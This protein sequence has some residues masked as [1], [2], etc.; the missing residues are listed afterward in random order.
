GEEWNPEYKE[1]YSRKMARTGLER[2]LRVLPET[3]IEVLP[4][5][6]LSLEEIEQN[7]KDGAY[8]VKAP[9][10]SSGKGL[11]GVSGQLGRKEKEW[12][13]GML[14]RQG[15]L[16]LEKRLDKVKDFAAEF[17]LGEKGVQF[18]GW[19]VFITGK[20]GEYRGNYIGASGNLE[21]EWNDYFS[22]HYSAL[23]IR[24]LSGMLNEL[25][26]CY[27]GYLGVDMMV[28][29]NCLGKYVVQPCVEINLRYNM[30][31]VA[32]HLYNRYIED[33]SR[34]MFEIRYF[35]KPGQALDEHLRLQQ[36]C[37]VVYKN[38]RIKSGYLN[39]TPVNES[40]RFVACVRCY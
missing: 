29:R 39:L 13:A 3:E 6:C 5:I 38:N 20:H 24:E 14:H 12:L 31:I 18:I 9:W 11:L 25:F 34:G 7:I 4:R 35:S 1:W 28:Y 32:L 10:S 22:S 40:T 30:G 2:L 19:S 16:M 8:L 33:S 15:Y 26:P 37:P 23:L 27:R 17:Y 21:K 36:E